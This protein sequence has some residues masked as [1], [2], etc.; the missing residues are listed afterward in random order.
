MSVDPMCLSGDYDKRLIVHRKLL[1]AVPFS[2]AATDHLSAIGYSCLVPYSPNKIVMGTID[3]Y[4]HLT[5]L[6]RL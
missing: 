2:P 3:H 5:L 4:R 6:V 1:L